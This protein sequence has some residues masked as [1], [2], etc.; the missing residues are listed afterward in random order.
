MDQLL[1]IEEIDSKETLEVYL[2]SRPVEEARVIALRCALRV[3]PLQEAALRSNGVAH[4]VKLQ[5]ITAIFRACFISWAKLSYPTVEIQ[6]ADRAAATAGA[7]AS[8]TYAP[9]A[10]CAAYATA[11]AAVATTYAEVAADAAAFAAAAFAAVDG[12]NAVIWLMV[13]DDLLFVQNSGPS[14]GLGG[15]I[16]GIGRKL[17]S[18]KD[19]EEQF[20]TQLGNLGD[21][22]SVIWDFYVSVRDGTLPFPHLGA[23]HE[24][25]IVGV[26]T[27][28]EAFW[29][30]D[31]DDV[32]M[33]IAERL[34]DGIEEPSVITPPT[35]PE[36]E[37]GSGPQYDILEGKLG[38]VTSQPAANEVD[39]QARLF[40]RLRRN[41][42]RLVSAAHKIDNSHPNLAFSIREYAELMD[43]SLAELDV[44]GVW[45]V[46]SSLAGFAQSFREQNRNRTL[47]EPL[48]PEVDGLLQSV[49]RQHGAFIIGFEEGRDLV[50]RAD[51]FA[52][53]A[54]KLSGL[55]ESGNPLIAELA[56]NADLV[57]VGTR[58]VHKSISDG[59]HE[60]G[61][62]TARVGYAA[63][64]VIR[65]VVLRTI[66]VTVAIGAL[67]SGITFLSAM[68]GDPNMEFLRASIPFLQAN[69]QDLLAFFSHSPEML[70]Y[71][72]WALHV[73]R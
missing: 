21:Q 14:H 40:E 35:P 66:K 56:S 1:T 42:D 16:W 53:D 13:R 50:D 71:V 73:I 29:D 3:I 20:E 33:E 55:E 24:E 6:Y 34:L 36:P 46:G 37:P 12:S 48:E 15:A 43:T 26:A 45:S 19:A 25:V 9:A 70:A 44:T 4:Q 41:V 30:R 2:R 11:A 38:I 32:M 8:A 22:W 51:R 39:K 58:A 5:S 17:D 59:V 18:I 68:S 62:K 60:F 52:L 28:E 72:Q 63:Y 23:R 27:E 67:G 47:A 61:W 69:A 65:N 7:A 31:P 10:I 54:D 64:L 49:I 57:N